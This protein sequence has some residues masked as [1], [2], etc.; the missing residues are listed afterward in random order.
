[1]YRCTVGGSQGSKNAIW[2]L[3]VSAH[4]INSGILQLPKAKRLVAVALYRGLHIRLPHHE[5]KAIIVGRA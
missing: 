1:M 2:H 5:F 3:R 4:G